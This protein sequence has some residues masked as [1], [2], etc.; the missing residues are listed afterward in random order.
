MKKIFSLQ[1]IFT[2][3]YIVLISLLVATIGA[4]II[5]VET[6]VLRQKTHVGFY[7]TWQFPML[8]AVLIDAAYYDYLKEF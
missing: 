1:K 4:G 2:L 6:I 8:L 5:F 7:N 3:Q